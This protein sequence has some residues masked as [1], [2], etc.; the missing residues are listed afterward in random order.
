MK[1]MVWHTSDSARLTSNSGAGAGSGAWPVAS[2][3]PRA[4]STSFFFGGIM[5]LVMNF[6]AL[7]FKL[8]VTCLRMARETAAI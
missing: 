4:A 7:T 5:L 2:G 1:S 3:M 6:K 8:V